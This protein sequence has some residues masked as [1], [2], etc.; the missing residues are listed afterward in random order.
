MS[1]IL[2]K[3]VLDSKD[4]KEPRSVLYRGVHEYENVN[5]QLNWALDSDEKQAFLGSIK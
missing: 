4:Y 3:S 5:M 2:N 1:S